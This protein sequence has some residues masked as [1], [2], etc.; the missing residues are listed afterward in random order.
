[1]Q[2]LGDK[3]EARK[4]AKKAK[5]PLVPGSNGVVE[6]EDD[7][8]KVAAIGEVKKPIEFKIA[9]VV[10]TIPLLVGG[11]LLAGMYFAGKHR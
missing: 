6:S 11:G 9:G 2:L 3:V 7:A 5:V 10:N 4:L 1:M 8:V